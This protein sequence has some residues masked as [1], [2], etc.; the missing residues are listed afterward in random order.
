MDSSEKLTK[1]EE[2]W[3]KFDHENEIFAKIQKQ[4]VRRDTEVKT[5]L[6][7][8]NARASSI[9]LFISGNTGTG[10]T[11]TVKTV[12][13]CTNVTHSVVNCVE[14]YTPQLV[15]EKIL[16]D[17]C[18]TEGW[19]SCTTMMDFVRILKT[20]KNITSSNEV[21]YILFDKAE[22]LRKLDDHVL[23]SFLRISELTR[24]NIGVALI[25]ELVLEKFFPTTGFNTPLPVHFG[26]Y[27]KQD[28]IAILELDCP[29][30]HSIDFYSPYCRLVVDVFY[31]VCR[32]V[33][34]LRHLA[35]VN[36]FKYCE[37]VKNKEVQANEVA[38]LFQ[39]MV[40]YLKKA[41]QT[42]YLREVSSAQWET[43]AKVE[44]VKVDLPFYA[45]YLLLAAYFSS[46][47]PA[48]T[49]RRFFTKKSQ[50]KLSS[51]AKSSMKKAKDVDKKFAGP[52]PFQVDRLMAIFYSIVPGGAT[53]SGNILTQL[54][55]LVTL[56]LLLKVSQDDVI[57]A[58]KY[59]CVVSLDF[60]VEIGKQVD[61]NVMEYLYNYT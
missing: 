16:S 60:V 54:S 19:T 30:S 47:N 36:F 3:S 56:N 57:D 58:P 26:D 15:Y 45:K 52:K 49:D 39:K 38:K 9:A 13:R 18:C 42:V 28:V 48:N 8:I 27:T 12:F 11:H 22:R 32:D 6:N 24:L 43:S 35:S 46:Y 53:S 37:P 61:L 29:D 44:K 1:H 50:G 51:R 7:L 2:F 10:K 33:K 55:S 4:C 40:P 41:L 14:T 59:K 20:S 31:M 5:I 23:S 21:H 17:F 34:E 25:T